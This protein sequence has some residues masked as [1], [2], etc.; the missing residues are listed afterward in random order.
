MLG[1]PKARDVT[2]QLVEYKWKPLYCKRC[3]KLGHNCDQSKPKT[4]QWK[5]KPKAYEKNTKTIVTP[6]E[7]PKDALVS[8]NENT[9]PLKNSK[10]TPWTAVSNAGKDKGKRPMVSCSP[11]SL[12][13]EN[14]F[15]AFQIL[16]DLQVLQDTGQ[17]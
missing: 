14:G 2:Q 6:A 3:Q 5:P 16:K 12:T 1:T 15:D 11:P 10:E 8:K 17:C 7:I 4:K 13:F 9:K